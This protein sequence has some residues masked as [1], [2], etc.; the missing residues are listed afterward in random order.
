MAFDDNSHYAE[1]FETATGKSLRK[2]PAGPLNLS[3]FSPDGRWLITGVDNGRVYATGTWEPGPQ[4]GAGEPSDATSELVVLAQTNGIYRLVELATG[5]ELAQL[6]DPEQNTRPAVF[7]PDGSKLIVAAMNGL[8]V[9]DLRRIRTELTKLGLD[10][11]APP[12]PAVSRGADATPLAATPLS[13]RVDLGA[14]NYVRLSQWD[15]AAGEYAQT[16]WSR[17]LREDN[18]IYACLFLIRGDN[19]GYDRFC[20]DMIQRAAQTQDPAEAYELARSCAVA[21]K[22]RIEPTRA[23]QWATQAIASDQHPWCFHVLGLAQYRAGQF[24]EAL[25]S[26][27][28]ANVKTWTWELNWF[29]LALVHYRLGH[30]DEARQCFDEGIQWLERE[31]PPSPELPA[32]LLPQDWL[33]AQLLRREAEEILNTKRSP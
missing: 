6:E 10:W 23:L 7:T 24:D 25:Q 33:E 5:R 16:D 31:G 20:Q 14:S 1:V 8:R 12:L 28:K 27:T 30:A 3:R 9:W 11:D 29:G 13:I 15:K 32:K 26:F 4:L 21:R 18:F 2:W 22:S 19:E 17:S